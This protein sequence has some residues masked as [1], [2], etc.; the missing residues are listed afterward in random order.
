MQGSPDELGN[1]G[2]VISRVN[3]VTHPTPPLLGRVWDKLIGYGTG[4]GKLCETRIGFLG[5][6]GFVVTRPTLKL[7]LLIYP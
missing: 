2:M 7:E 5:G 1:L 3:R 6:Y 4:M